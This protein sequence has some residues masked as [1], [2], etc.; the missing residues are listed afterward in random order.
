MKIYIYIILAV[1]MLLPVG[2]VIYHL[3]PKVCYYPTGEIQSITKNLS[4]FNE[5]PKYTTTYYKN[6]NIL[7]KGKRMWMREIENWEYYYENGQ[8]SMVRNYRESEVEGSESSS[9]LK[10]NK[11]KEL[12][13]YDNIWFENKKADELIISLYGAITY[14]KCWDRDGNE[15]QCLSNMW[16]DIVKNQ[17]SFLLKK[18][19]KKK[20]QFD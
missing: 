1:V 16:L 14:Q 2:Y 9:L 12:H 5:Y 11:N 19:C 15:V 18:D 8:L 6:G 7:S 4:F 13:N 20:L 17:T 10:R 3:I